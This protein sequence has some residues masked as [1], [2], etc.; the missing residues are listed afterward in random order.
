MKGM[1]RQIALEIYDFSFGICDLLSKLIYLLNTKN[2]VLTAKIGSYFSKHDV[3][4]FLF[5][6]I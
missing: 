1:G 5:F 3:S 4:I 2:K 6:F